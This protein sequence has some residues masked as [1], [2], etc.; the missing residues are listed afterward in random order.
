MVAYSRRDEVFRALA[1]PSRRLLLDSLNERNGQTLRELG[2]RLDMA[3]QSVSK[4]LAVLEA[5][6]LV[7]TV[8]RGREKHHY[9]NAAPINEIAERW[10]TRYDQERVRALSDLKR[11][12][13][14]T[15]MEKP[16]FVYTTY[17]RTTPE[18]LWQALTEPSFT[19]R[20][21]QTTFETEWTA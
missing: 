20:W 19:R 6:N 5:A 16:E 21:W 2:S 11:A 14:E 10:I 4:H 7:T 3:R 12:L 8:R 15:P 9:L 13:E 18:R 17:I 1:D